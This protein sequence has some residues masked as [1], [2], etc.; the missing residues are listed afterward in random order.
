VKYDNG[1][2]I[3]LYIDFKWFNVYYSKLK[4]DPNP[5]VGEPNKDIAI[6]AMPYGTAPANAK[7]VW[8]FGDGKSAVTVK[9]DSTV[10]YKY[11]KEGDFDVT[12]DLYDNSNNTLL[13][14]ATAKATVVNGIL[15]RLQKYQ[16]LS[17]DFNASIKS[18]VSY[19][20]FSALSIDNSPPWGT[21]QKCP[22][23]WNGANFSTTYD[24]SWTSVLGEKIHNTGAYSGTM[25]ANGL[26]MNSLTAHETSTHPDSKDVYNYDISVTNVPYQSNYEYDAY[27][28]R[29]AVEGTS[30]S[31]HISSYSQK[32]DFVDGQGKA[33]SLNS[34]SVDYNDPEDVPY[35]HITFSGSK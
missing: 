30:V 14:H 33:G 35:L 6:K 27:S 15:S 8:N 25:S 29:F 22:L 3:D 4:I 13:G 16:Y 26:I 24:Y 7:Y 11:T 9:N 2:Y 31:S 19:I 1:N 28:P 17:I 23:T 5:I 12:V 10:K 20:S 21:S 34:T 18:N 32:W